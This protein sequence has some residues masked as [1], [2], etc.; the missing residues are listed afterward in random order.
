MI[1]LS[2]TWFIHYYEIKIYSTS[3]FKSLVNYEIANT[4]TRV[5]R[6]KY[7]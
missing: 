6:E 2:D 4:A 1:S 7:T 5:M 3:K